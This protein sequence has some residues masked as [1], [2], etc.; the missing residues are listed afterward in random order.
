[1]SIQRHAP[2]TERKNPLQRTI[3]TKRVELVIVIVLSLATLAAGF[4]LGADDSKVKKATTQVES[5][6]R[7]IPD[8]RVGEGVDET[9]KGIGKTVS[10]GAKYSGEKLK[11]A[12]KAA[13]PTAKTAW[14]DGRAAAVGFGHT[15]R[16]FFANLFAK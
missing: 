12:G 5:G 13:E 10:E 16:G 8:G 2:S 6:A 1:M 11:E 14:G 9:A 7:K 3:S 15:V 4:A